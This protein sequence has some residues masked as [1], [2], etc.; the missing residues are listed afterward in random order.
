MKKD[1]LS[2]HERRYYQNSIIRIME[3][4]KKKG[5]TDAFEIQL[6]KREIGLAWQLYDRRKILQVLKTLAS[7]GLV[8]RIDKGMNFT[9]W[10]FL[11]DI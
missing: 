4:I 1:I 8:E 9:D 11:K 6:H 3:F 10:K 7:E 5:Q 2:V